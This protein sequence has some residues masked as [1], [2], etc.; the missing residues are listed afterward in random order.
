MNS[1]NIIEVPFSRILAKLLL[2]SNIEDENIAFL[3]RHFIFC[4]LFFP[5]TL[6]GVRT[7]WRLHA[8]GG[9]TKVRAGDALANPTKL[10]AGIHPRLRETARWLKCI[11]RIHHF[12][13]PFTLS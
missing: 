5:F 9:F 2:L 10:S 1:L 11:Y 8:G 12:V 4:F 6:N 3:L 7:G 13:I